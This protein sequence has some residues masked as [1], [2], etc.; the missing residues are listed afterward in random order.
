MN[1]LR[2][3]VIG[4]GSITAVALVLALAAPKAAHGIVATFVQVVNPPSSPV[5]AVSAPSQ[6]YQS[7]CIGQY[8]NFVGFTVA[9]CA[10]QA[11]PTGYRLIIE[12][13]S[14]TSFSDAGADPYSFEIDPQG[15]G[16]SPEMFLPLAKQPSVGGLDVYTAMTGARMWAQ[17]GQTPFFQ[18]A[19]NS[20]T[21]NGNIACSAS[22]YLVPTQ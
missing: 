15:E 18:A 10:L 7:G 21:T 4:I 2:R 6:V 19:L 9:N 5:L 14:V 20:S 16:T 13:V 17:P 11:V 12:S 22:G 8:Q 1:L 3:V